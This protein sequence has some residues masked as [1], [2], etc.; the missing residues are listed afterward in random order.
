MD[1]QTAPEQRTGTSLAAIGMLVLVLIMSAF[2]VAAAGL[3]ATF[4]ALVN[5]DYAKATQ[6]T[7]TCGL[8]AIMLAA[9]A[10]S[11][12]RWTRSQR[13]TGDELD[14]AANI[15]ADLGESIDEPDA[16]YDPR[17]MADIPIDDLPCGRDA[18]EWGYELRLCDSCSPAF[19]GLCGPGE[20]QSIGIRGAGDMCASCGCTPRDAKGIAEQDLAGILVKA[21]DAGAQ[22]AELQELFS[23]TMLTVSAELEYK[24]PDFSH[25]SRTWP[26]TW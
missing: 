8:A 17:T 10:I 23:G 6:M 1:H 12:P 19:F 13:D 15:H 14:S 9:A 11:T 5:N 18:L 4:M 2:A 3:L 7:S 22:P 21:L 25:R 16:V 20:E 26:T 24:L